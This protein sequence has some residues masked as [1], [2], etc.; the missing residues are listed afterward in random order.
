MSSR[1]SSDQGKLIESGDQAVQ[2]EAQE[3]LA[4][5][6]REPE[7][8]AEQ[9][10]GEQ[11]K[12]LMGPHQ[13]ELA[14]AAGDLGMWDWNITT[15][16]IYLD[17]GWSVILGY[18]PDEYDPNSRMW[19][20][21]IHPDDRRRV[22][23]NLKRHL[24]GIIPSYESE[25]R[26]RA[27][28]G[29]W[30]WVLDRGKIVERDSHDRPTRMVG[31]YFDITARKRVEEALH[32][33]EE[34]LRR[35]FET[36]E[37]CIYFKDAFLTYTEV[38]PA[39]C[40]LLG[41]P[42]IRIIGHT[43]E[44]LFGK[45]EAQ[46]IEDSDRL[47]LAGQ[48]IEQEHTKVLQGIE[49]T[50]LE[51]K[52]PLRNS[53]GEVVGIFGISRDVTHRRQVEAA[54]KV[55]TYETRS[56]IMRSVL[57]AARAAAQTD[58]IVLL[59]GESGAGKDFVAHYIHGRS[60]RSHG[61]FFAINCA[62]ISTELAESELFGYEPGAFTGARGAKKGLLELAEGGT[63][64]LNEIGEL[65][66][67]VQ[68]KLLTFLDT[69][70]FNRVGGVKVC[71]V[72]ARLIA[73]TNQNLE[74]AVKQNRFRKDLFYRLEVISI[75]V[76]PLRERPEDI[77]LLVEQLLPTLAHNMGI[78]SP[79]EVTPDALKALEGYHWP[80]NVRELR[81]VLERAL[82]LCN[83]KAITV[84]DIAFGGRRPANDINKEWSMNI[85]FP[86]DQ[87]LNDV[88]LSVKRRLVVEA[89]ER[90]GGRRKQAATLLGLT[91]DALKHYMKIFDLY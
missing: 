63:I 87:S 74:Q 86:K 35:M 40:A 67:V 29:E 45:A 53:A 11:E 42:A 6:K 79:P 18:S 38:N 73:A 64:L 61:P 10:S 25:Y 15:G 83:R 9:E 80:G 75:E 81:N 65:S 60:K 20:R 82:I 4:A 30:K 51:I 77:P 2:A 12:L 88:V 78:D 41:R 84:K 24:A 16:A 13:L 37:D 8:H 56:P 52:T 90:A 71:S 36:A 14:I 26:I 34:R 21:L 62:A 49:T 48:T 28:S 46:I 58:S 43:D 89:L 23:K 55:G 7:T 5:S 32:Q 68:S 69:R 85:G 17:R 31:I 22:F 44:E 54:P 66:P 70:Q 33:S 39:M 91:A 57:T 72:N 47:V 3:A 76:P 59:T 50:F 27:K 19:K 1:S